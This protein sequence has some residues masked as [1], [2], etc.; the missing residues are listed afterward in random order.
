M[1]ITMPEIKVIG[2][3]EMSKFLWW[4]DGN[5]LYRMVKQPTA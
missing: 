1:K 3:V 4:I 2:F 5:N